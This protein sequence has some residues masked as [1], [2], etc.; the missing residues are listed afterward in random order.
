MWLSWLISTILS[1]LYFCVLVMLTFDELIY[2]EI[3]RRLLEIRKG[4]YTQ[5]Q[6]A[7]ALAVRG[8]QLKRASIANIENGKQRVMLHIL[9]EIAELLKVDISKLLP[10]IAE[11]RGTN[12]K[13]KNET[14]DV[15]W[16]KDLTKKATQTEG[17]R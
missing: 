11:V 8:V 5:E 17:E 16:A 3:G 4:K 12:G 2:P 15:A 9:Y 7:E 13:Q 10:T 1:T 6:L 14:A